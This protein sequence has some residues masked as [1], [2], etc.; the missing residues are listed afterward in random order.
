[1]INIPINIQLAELWETKT[2]SKTDWGEI[3]LIVGP[4]GTGKSLFAEQLKNQLV[5]KQFKVRLLNAERLSGFE[6]Q[7]YN[8]FSGSNFERGLNISDF[9]QLKSNGESYGLSSSAFIT[10]KERLDVRVKI[11]ALLSDIFNKTIRLVE[12]GG[13]LKP[14][15]QNLHGGIE[16]GLKEKECHG[17][18][19]IITLLTFLYDESKNCL[20]LDE[21]E[22]HLHPQFQSFFL[23]EIRKFAGNPQID[24]T[25]KIFFIITHSPYFIDLRSIDDLKSILVCHF[26]QPPDYIKSLDSQDEYILKKFLPRFNTHHKQFFFSPNPVFVEGYT[27][28]QIITLLFDKLDFNISASGSSIIDVGGKDELAVFFRLCKELN[29]NANIIADLDAFFKGKLREVASSDENCNTYIQEKGLGTDLSTLIG[30]LD[31]KL[32]E[33]ADDLITKTTTDNDLNHLINFIKPINSDADKR[34]SVIIAMLI[35]L[36]RFKD[37]IISIATQNQ[38]SNINYIIPRFNQLLEAFKAANIFI[39]PKGEIEHY[40]TQTTLDYLHFTDKEKN[41]SFHCE[42]DY[43]LSCNDINELDTKYEELIT[44]LKSSVPQIKVNLSKHLKYIIVE[45]IQTIQRAIS[46]GDINDLVG[47]K[48]NAKIDY[49]IFNQIIDKIDLQI[50]S[51]KRFTCKIMINKSLTEQEKEIEFNEKTIPH[52]FEFEI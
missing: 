25:K 11:E 27:D 42:R 21:P 34:N 35:S 10:L 16:Y 39:F 9:Q 26:N 38:H 14:K 28:Q 45:W 46:K 8:S 5:Q 17:L 24:N 1:M 13:Y 48:S 41:T 22:L 19:E 40:Y 49:K 44:V 51:D 32:K 31:R 3:N 52:E 4:N 47:L 50:Q 18:K 20:I 15:I 33:I 2:F 30:E 29:I 6:R 7:S 36:N 23:S 43:I 12:E 37:K